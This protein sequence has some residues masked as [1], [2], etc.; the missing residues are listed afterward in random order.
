MPDTLEGE[1]VS[2][3]ENSDRV[4][5]EFLGHIK[6]IVWHG[7]GKKHN[8]C[9]GREE[10]ENVIDRVFEPGRKHLIGLV[11]TEHLD[12]VGLE[13]TAVDHVEDTTWGSDHDMRT[14]IQFCHVISDRSTTDTSV[15]VDVEVVS[16]GNDDLLDLLSELTGRRKDE[17]LRLFDSGV[18]LIQYP[19]A[20][21]S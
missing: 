16:K 6:H 11:E 9:L 5:H 14:I 7:G 2:L 1:L 4:T 15:A 13:S 8:L 3:D 19:S 18:N 21:H 10:L 17:G 12:R 20:K